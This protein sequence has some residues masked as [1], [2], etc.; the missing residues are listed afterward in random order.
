M[1]SFRISA[2]FPRS[3]KPLKDVSKAASKIILLQGVNKQ[4]NMC[5][6]ESTTQ[7]DSA[8]GTSQPHGGE[9]S[10]NFESD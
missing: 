6:R 7:G 1:Q 4:I 5:S 9:M 8:S 2:M 3:I 10:Q